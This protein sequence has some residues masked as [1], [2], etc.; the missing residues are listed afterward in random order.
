MNI[1]KVLITMLVTGMSII[2]A[3]SSFTAGG[4]IRHRFEM[5]DKGLTDDSK[6]TD[7]SYLRTRLNLPFSP[8][9]NVV[10]LIQV[11][12]SRILGEE[13]QGYFSFV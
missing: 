9:E 7:I 11:Q 8:A 10:T 12:D 5:S 4:Q 13:T 6:R 3:Q 1:N 2:S